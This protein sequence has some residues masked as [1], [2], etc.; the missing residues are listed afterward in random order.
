MMFQR[1]IRIM[2]LQHSSAK[3]QASIQHTT[4]RYI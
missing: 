4:C 3:S 1:N 2:F